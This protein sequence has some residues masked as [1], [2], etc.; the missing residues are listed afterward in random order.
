[1]RAIMSVRMGVWCACLAGLFLIAHAVAQPAPKTG[2]TPPPKAEVK[3]QLK[4][5]GNVMVDRAAGKLMIPGTVVLR[6]GILDYLCVA[7]SSGKDYESLIEVNCKPSSIHAGLLAL[8][9]RP[10][11]IDKKF[12]TAGRGDHAG[13]DRRP[14][15]TKVKITVRVGEGDKA[16]ET[17]I[18]KWVI[19]RATKRPA[20]ELVWVFTGSL[21]TPKPDGKGKMY[22]ADQE[23]LAVSMLYHGA[24]VLNLASSA[25]SPYDADDKGYAVNSKVVPKLKTKVWLVFYVVK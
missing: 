19:R 12:K 6:D 5:I 2:P 4:R 7:P 22:L 21:M 25:G 16:T 20:K 1:M 10:G 23:R 9:A 24:C 14:V 17:P 18:S 15:G 3:K 13:M 8:G 11:K